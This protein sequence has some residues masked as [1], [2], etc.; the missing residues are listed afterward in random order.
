[1]Y[2]K[3]IFKDTKIND[4]IKEDTMGGPGSGRKKG[5][6]KSNRKPS[7]KENLEFLRKKGVDNFG[8]KMTNGRYDFTKGKKAQPNYPKGSK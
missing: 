4:V 8:A 6:G 2:F 1:M 7:K 5:G 3:S